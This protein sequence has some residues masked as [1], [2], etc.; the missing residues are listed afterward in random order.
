MKAEGKIVDVIFGAFD[1]ASADHVD[2][3]VVAGEGFFIFDLAEEGFAV[4]E[5]G[6]DELADGENGVAGVIAVAF[7][8][9]GDVFGVNAGGDDFAGGEGEGVEGHTVVV[10]A[11]AVAVFDARGDDGES[12]VS[13]EVFDALG[14]EGFGGGGA[15]DFAACDDVIGFIVFVTGGANGFRESFDAAAGQ[16]AECEADPNVETEMVIAGHN[17]FLL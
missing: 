2:I 12:I 15:A 17:S 3:N 7:V 9:F 10:A 11:A 13:F 6:F 16:E 5:V 8:D 14:A 1:G 4:F